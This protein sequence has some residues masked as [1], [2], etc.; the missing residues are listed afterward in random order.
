MTKLDVA[1]A[2]LMKLGIKSISSFSDTSEQAQAVNQEYNNVRLE[3]LREHYWPRCM[4]RIA[5]AQ[6]EIDTDLDDGAYQ[7][8]YALPSDCVKPHSLLSKAAYTE[9]STFLYTDD[10]TAVLKYLSSAV[11]EPDYDEGLLDCIATK[12][13]YVL[14][15][16]LTKD[17]ERLNQIQ[18]EFVYKLRVNKNL[19]TQER[20]DVQRKSTLWVDQRAP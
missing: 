2:A 20:T 9:E 1:N 18:Q 17:K 12:L 7:Y 15:M 10:A 8:K 11:V 4:K 3:V 5:L 13:A 19:A 16:R 14:C 6:V